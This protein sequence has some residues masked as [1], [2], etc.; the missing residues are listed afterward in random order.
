M[1][2]SSAVLDN[3]NDRTVTYMRMIYFDLIESRT[4]NAGMPLKRISRVVTPCL[5]VMHA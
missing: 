5:D 4:A 2:C 3:M 1:T